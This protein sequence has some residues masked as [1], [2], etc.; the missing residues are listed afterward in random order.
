[1]G[2]HLLSYVNN[3]KKEEKNTGT[4]KKNVI[5]PNDF[6]FGISL[7][8]TLEGNSSLLSA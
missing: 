5:S 6:F 2:A 1:M 7:N 4:R 3:V 8:V